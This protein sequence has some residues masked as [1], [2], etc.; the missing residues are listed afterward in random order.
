MPNPDRRRFLQHLAAIGGAVTLPGILAHCTPGRRPLNILFILVDDMGWRDVG[1]MGS[2]Y[3]ETPHIDALAAEGMVFTQAY[4][5]A[6]NCAP[7]RASLLTGQYTPRQGIYPV[8][9]PDRGDSGRRKL[10]SIPNETTLPADAFTV[11]E[12]LREAGYATA[13]LGKW[14]LGDGAETGPLGQ[15]F[16][17][18]IGGNHLGHPASYFSPYRNEDLPDGPEGEQLTERLTAEAMAFLERHRDQPFFLYLTLYAVHTPL[19][20]RANLV[21]KYEAKP[22][23]GGQRNATYAAM[24]ETVDVC[25]GRLLARLDE[26]GLSDNT[27]VVFF[28]DN[29]G[30]GGITSQAPLRGGKGMLYEG[31][32]RVPMAVRWPGTV[33]PGTTCDDP[34]IG[35]DFFPTLLEA[36]GASPPEDGLVDGVS[37]LPLLH[38]GDSLHRHGLFW[39]FPAYLEGQAQG[40]RDPHFRTRPGGAV[41][42]GDWKLIEYFEDG[43]LELYN[44]RED[45][46]ETRNLA[47]RQ[48]ARARELHDLM[49]AWRQEVE[50]PVPTEPN[51]AYREES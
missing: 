43:A 44:L 22:G 16:D 19:Q 36:A 17:V 7:S 23:D 49:V 13:S 48:P 38:G 12:G 27:L 34:V 10:L 8:G 1:F 6:P 18:N 40:A 30:V 20:A 5:N 39:H 31:G 35:M 2:R 51:P 25:V 15:G 42:Q 37:L 28:S 11:A 21:A 9:N 45:V 32:L 3:Y 33:R 46:G 50:A 41:R 24:V 26:L 14:H 4:T 29:G 47:D